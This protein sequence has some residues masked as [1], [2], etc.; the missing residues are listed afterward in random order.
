MWN[1]VSPGLAARRIVLV[2]SGRRK[3]PAV[4]AMV[5]GEVTVA[6]P[7]SVLQ[8]HPDAVALLDGGAAA[9]LELPGTLS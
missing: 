3:A 4:R 8:R 5:T 6:V 2:A 1:P 7:A 9:E